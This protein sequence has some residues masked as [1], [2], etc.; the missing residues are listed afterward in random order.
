MKL[1]KTSEVAFR[2]ECVGYGHKAT[3]VHKMRAQHAIDQAVPFPKPWRTAI[4]FAAEVAKKRQAAISH[5]VKVAGNSVVDC[6]LLGIPR[7]ADVLDGLCGKESGTVVPLVSSTGAREDF[8][9]A[10]HVNDDVWLCH[11]G[12]LTEDG[13]CATD[14]FGIEDLVAK[15]IR[16][17]QYKDIGGRPLH[18]ITRRHPK[19]DLLALKA[20]S[21]SAWAVARAYAL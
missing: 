15:D 9:I 8:L 19:V 18:R 3:L 16:A 4:K 17:Q 7:P 5:A 1:K 11:P 12:T 14:P 21:P 20:L 2:W 10:A 13:P 6:E